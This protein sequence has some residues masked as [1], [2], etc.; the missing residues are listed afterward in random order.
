M[1]WLVSLVV[2]VLAG[3][4][5]GVS[6]IVALQDLK[7]PDSCI[8]A[9][10]VTEPDFPEIA[11]AASP[12]A[13]PVTSPVAAGIVQSVEPVDGQISQQLESLV[14]S[15]A[16]C[17]SAGDARGIATLT[18]AD[19]RGVV[20]G[21]GVRLSQTDFLAL[22]ESAPITPVRVLAVSNG[23]FSGMRTVS[24]DVGLVVGS[25]LLQERWTFVFRNADIPSDGTA[26][27][28]AEQRSGFWLVHGVETMPVSVPA[29]SARIQVM[30]DEHTLDF[31]PTTMRGP[32]VTLV[33]RNIGNEPHE[34]LVIRLQPEAAS[35]DLLLPAADGFP[36]GIEIVGQATTLPGDQAELVL[37][38]LVSGTYT[39]VCLFPDSR[40]VPHLALGQEASF[41]V[42]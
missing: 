25:Q 10:I 1:V 31:A 28:S 38:D 14:R 4:L 18:T 7:T 35:A 24:A 34:M 41:T 39:I 6:G 2:I 11:P 9:A 21:G 16:A 32:D 17:K 12:I 30:L 37:I 42:Q 5:F 22:M 36:P 13:S 29:G 40:G 27:E 19:Y 23:G 3:A 8:G 20:Y 15:L 26:I 33:G